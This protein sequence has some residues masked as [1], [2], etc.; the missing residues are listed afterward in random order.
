MKVCEGQ[1]IEVDPVDRR[2]LKQ[3][4]IRFCIIVKYSDTEILHRS[5]IYCITHII[6]VASGY[7]QALVL[8]L[9]LSENEVAAPQVCHYSLWVLNLH[10]IFRLEL[11]CSLE[12]G[13]VARGRPEQPPCRAQ[14]KVLLKSCG[15]RDP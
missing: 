9:Q 4:K 1:R 5:K 7:R 3:V 10:F 15:S 13:C 11:K 2:H 12:A 14:V 8:Q 6:K